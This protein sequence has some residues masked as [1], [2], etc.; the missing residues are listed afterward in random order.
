MRHIEC[1]TSESLVCQWVK[2][3]SAG[4]PRT[5]TD[6]L[7]INDDRG[8]KRTGH[9]LAAVTPAINENA[10]YILRRC[11]SDRLGMCQSDIIVFVCSSAH[12]SYCLRADRSQSAVL[13]L[14][15]SVLYW[16]MTHA[17]PNINYASVVC[18]RPAYVTLLCSRE[19]A[20]DKLDIEESR[21]EPTW[22]FWNEMPKKN[23]EC[24]VVIEKSWNERGHIS[25]SPRALSTESWTSLAACERRQAAKSSRNDVLISQLAWL[26]KSSYQ[27]RRMTPVKA[28]CVPRA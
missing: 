19:T 6:W 28:G 1:N 4:R 25:I 7:T 23:I 22:G 16:P 24:E 3:A 26:W 10:K 14:S 18:Q 5:T 20:R 27:A 2:P 9:V 13:S 12:R 17:S 21:Y 11:S 15:N 8:I